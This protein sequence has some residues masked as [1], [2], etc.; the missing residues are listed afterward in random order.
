MFM[1]RALRTSDNGTHSVSRTSRRSGPE[2]N[3]AL[4][5]FPHT[6]V[7]VRQQPDVVEQ[8]PEFD[9]VHPVDVEVHP[10]FDKMDPVDVEVHAEVDKMDPVDVE[11][12]PVDVEVHAEVDKVDP[13]DVEVH[14]EVVEVDPVDVEVHR[15]FDK[16]HPVDVR[17]WLDPRMPASARYGRGVSRE[18]YFACS[19][20]MKASASSAGSGSLKR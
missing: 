12:H 14:P 8:K 4:R 10:E 5:G 3:A 11:V 9:K 18:P 1:A 20:R 19:L 6:H 7:D 13:D 16:V 15:E 2:I 17:L